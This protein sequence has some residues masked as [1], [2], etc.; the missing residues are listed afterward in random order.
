MATV[1]VQR[2]T[3]TA[4]VPTSTTAAGGGDSISGVSGGSPLFIRFTVGANATTVTIDDPNSQTPEGAT[5]FNPDITSGSF[6]S[7][8]RIMKINNPSRFI[9][10]TTGLINMTYNQVVGLVWEAWQ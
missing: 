4:A 8:S 6:T 9:N 7:A 3:L 10:P 1:A 2:P 5:A